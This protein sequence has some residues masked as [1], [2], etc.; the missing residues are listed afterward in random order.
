MG[1]PAPRSQ[2]DEVEAAAAVVGEAEASRDGKSASGG[3]GTK[4][5]RWL[6]LATWVVGSCSSG[7]GSPSESDSVQS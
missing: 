6:T 3:A 2:F 4:T 7:S 5:T 1:P